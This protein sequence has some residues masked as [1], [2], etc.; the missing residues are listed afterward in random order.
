[1]VDDKRV[2]IMGGEKMK[3]WLSASEIAKESGVAESTTRRYLTNFEK[4]LKVISRGR[5]RKYHSDTVLI[6]KRCKDLF[7]SGYESNEVENVLQKEHGIVIE[8]ENQVELFAEKTPQIPTYED[9]QK[10]IQTEVSKALKEQDKRL[11][12]RDQQLMS[13]INEILETK[14]EIAA[15]LEEKN[16][17]KW[18][19]FW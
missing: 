3:E 2:V 12:E 5:G 14:K 17:K 18:W 1:M 15:S 8:E 11:E 10:L 7:D 19:K 6:I 16:E 4:Y 9:I 13:G